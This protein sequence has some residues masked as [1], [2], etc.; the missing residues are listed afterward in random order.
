[1][2]ADSVSYVVRKDLAKE[3]IWP[4]GGP[5]LPQMDIELTERCNNNCVHCYINRAEYDQDVLRR[6]MSTRQVKDILDEAAALGCMTVRFTGGE[7]LLRDDFQVIYLYTRRLGIKVTL[8]TNATRI[9][10]EL[11]ALFKRYPP[12]EPVTITLYG[13]QDETYESTSRAKGSFAAAMHGVHL[14]VENAIPISL[15][16]I[17]LPGRDDD[18]QKFEAFAK[19]YS[20]EGKAGG[21]S[22]NFN[23]RGRR[24]SHDKN[25]LIKKLRAT[26]TETLAVYTRNNEQYIQ[27]KKQFAAKFMRPGGADLFN[28]GCG[29]G[30][31]VDAYGNFQPCLLLRNPE[32]VYD[33]KKGTLRDALNSFFPKILQKEAKASQYLAR[34]AQC[35]LKG[36]CDQCPAWSWM[37]NGTLDTPVEY[38][39]DVAHA[40][41]RYLGLINPDE[42]A[43]QV[44]NWQERIDNFVKNG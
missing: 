23:L 32:M 31:S 44:H 8:F 37:E 4:S 5:Q 30:G 12:G 28:C 2:K 13:M 41:A 10:A 11:V 17:R 35:F 43:W 7:P 20:A 24:D 3:R 18:L 9:T 6:E 22:M 26:P 29:K 39:C 15:K 40:Q 21:I 25:L 14:L 1:M 33:L 19:H 27:A 42:K 36:L 16:T 38:L 34:C